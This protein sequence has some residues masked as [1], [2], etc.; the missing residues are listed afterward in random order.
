MRDSGEDDKNI[1]SRILK[2]LSDTRY[3]V[4]TLESN[5]TGTVK[6]WVDAS[7]TVHHDM[8]S[9]T[10]GVTSMGQGSLYSASSKQKLNMKVSNEAELVG[11]DDWMPQ[12]L[13]MQYF[14]EAQGMKVSDNLVYQ[15]N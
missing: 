8:K 3:L 10:G 5:G 11:V 9:H 4:L 7:F 13:W 2:Y 15:D 12:I 1:L 6:W 14:L